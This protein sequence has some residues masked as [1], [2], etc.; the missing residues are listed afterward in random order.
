M[1]YQRG[2]M[3]RYES[4]EGCYR[5][6]CA[7]E[8]VQKSDSDLLD[9]KKPAAQLL[10][11]SKTPS[12]RQQHMSNGLHDPNGH[13]NPNSRLEYIINSMAYIRGELVSLY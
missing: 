8:V 9:S 6:S 13:S 12:S 2:S 7:S 1:S 11:S 10:A 4:Y 3:K 5:A